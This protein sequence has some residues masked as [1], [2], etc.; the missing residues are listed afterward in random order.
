[1][2]E[3]VEGGGK[4]KNVLLPSSKL[5]VNRNRDTFLEA[6]ALVRRQTDNV[7]HTLKPQTHVKVLGDRL[8]GPEFVVHA[9][10]F[11]LAVVRN[12]LDCRPPENSVVSDKRRDIATSHGKPD[13]GVD[14]IGEEGDALLEEV[15]GHVH[16]SGRELQNRDFGALLHLA[17]SLEQAVLGH[18]SVRIDQKN[19]VA[20]ADISICPGFASMLV[21]GSLHGFLVGHVF[22]Q[23]TP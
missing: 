15:V 13:H 16:D 20:Y 18:T 23:L 7:A 9:A 19:V 12:L 2:G 3:W 10:V 1:M 6:V 4:K 22:L 5:V 11:V 17:D 8:L 21:H 14:H